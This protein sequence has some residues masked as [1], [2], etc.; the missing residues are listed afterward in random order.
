MI[1]LKKFLIIITIVLLTGCF[2]KSGYL[3]NSCVK[4]EK[5]NTL[6]S[7]TTYT[8]GFKNDIIDA[9]TVSYQYEDVDVITISSIKLSVETQNQYWKDKVTFTVVKDEPV[10]YQ[11]EYSIDLNGDEEIK[12]HFL[13]KQKRSDLVKTLKEQGFSCK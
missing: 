11:V 3:T 6:T 10:K 8:F 13:I 5:A 2:E 9:V 1:R 7:T 4:E 12:N